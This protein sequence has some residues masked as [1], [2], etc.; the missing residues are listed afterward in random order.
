MKP[1]LVILVW[2]VFVVN[3]PAATRYVNVNNSNPSPPYTNW[4]TAANVI[5]DAVDAAT[6]G[7]EIVVTN[8]VHATGGRAAG[9]SLLLNRVA[10]DKPITLRSVNG[11]QYTVIQGHQVPGTTI[12]DGAIRCVY[13]TN[14][15]RLL[16]FTLTSG[17]TRADAVFFGTQN[18]GGGVFCEST[19][20]VISNCVFVGNAAASYGG[21]SYGGTLNNCTF[22]SNSA[23][24]AGG[25]TCY[26]MLN[27]C[28][29]SANSGYYGGGAYSG[30]LNNCALTGNSAARDGGGAY[31]STLNNCA[32]TGNSASSYGGGA[33]Y[34]TLN[35]CTL[36]GN[37]ASSGGGTIYGTLNNCIVYFNTAPRGPNHI[38]ATL[39]Y[40]CT[41]PLPGS[42]TGGF[43]TEPQLA[44]FSNLSA[45]SPCLGA[46]NAAYATGVDLDGEAWASPPSIGCDEPHPGALTGPLSV[47]IQASYTNVTEGFEVSF[48]AQIGG[49]VGASQWEFGDGTIASNRPYASH[50]WLAAGD[51]DVVLR[52][53]NESYPLGVSATVTVHV[54]QQ[55]IHYVSSDSAS[56]LAPYASWAT[57]AANIQDA[58]DAATVPG[59][60]VLVTNGIYVTGGRAVHGTMT[61]RVAVDKPLALRSVNGPQFTVIQGYQLPGTTNGD[62]AVRCVYMTNGA[63]LSGF[64]LTGGATRGQGVA[65]RESSGG[66]LWCESHQF[67][68][69]WCDVTLRT[70]GPAEHILARC[71]T[72]P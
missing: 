49:R 9:T 23:S 30:T 40:C 24:Y 70:R 57:A 36:T 20:E 6:A 54:V 31:S 38:Y 21:G 1:P 68:T 15:A 12:G 62:G 27:N 18:C 22:T 47:A 66:G 3:S 39:N 43:T 7:D 46:G 11:P 41:T 2:L 29:L 16:G 52:A 48:T 50:S 56:P 25:G 51:Y 19:N 44:G 59:A 33:Y 14:G 35:N 65:E 37:S 67:S 69:A 63:S 45:N 55:P 72:A 58:V 26:G 60:L 28:T 32:L 61:N 53:Y 17:A 8:G 4:A 5:Q 34:A 10:V 71:I 42:G 13:L 64:T